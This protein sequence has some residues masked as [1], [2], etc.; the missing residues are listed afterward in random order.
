VWVPF[1]STVQDYQEH[2]NALVSHISTIYHLEG[3]LVILGPLGPHPCGRTITLPLGS[4]NDHALG[5]SI[6]GPC[7]YDLASIGPT[8]NVPSTVLTRGCYLSHLSRPP[9]ESS[10]SKQRRLHPLRCS[11]AR[12]SGH[13]TTFRQ[14]RCWNAAIRGYTSTVTSLTCGAIN[15]QNCSTSR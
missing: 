7:K 10:R 14:R 5:T 15:A 13:F 9:H 6:R 3:R 1:T 8:H 11:K 2:F 4:I 12:H